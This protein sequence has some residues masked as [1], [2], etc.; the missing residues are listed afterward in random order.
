MLL[1]VRR[2]LLEASAS[3]AK[4]NEITGA[5][6]AR[7]TRAERAVAEAEALE[8]LIGRIEAASREDPLDLQAEESSVQEE[9]AALMRLGCR[10]ALGREADKGGSALEKEG[11]EE[12]DAVARELLKKL[13]RKATAESARA[14]LVQCGIWDVKIA[15]LKSAHDTCHPDDLLACVRT[16]PNHVLARFVLTLTASHPHP[17][18]DQ[19]TFPPSF[20]IAG[21]VIRAQV[22]ENLELIRLRV[23]TQFDETI[24][25]EVR[26]H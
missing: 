3:S 20:T 11:K 9:F 22:H 17:G 25:Q 24:E 7:K 16:R 12:A 6:L 18:P 14:L 5:T 15:S 26:R 2:G 10:A 13:R 8:S 23:P 19:I 1:P 21:I 4:C